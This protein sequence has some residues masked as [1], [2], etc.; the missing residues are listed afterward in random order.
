MQTT[1]YGGTAMAPSTSSPGVIGLIP[2]S[3]Q[4]EQQEPTFAVTAI[5]HSEDGDAAAPVDGSGSDTT[6]SAPQD[7]EDD[8]QQQ[9]HE[10]QAEPSSGRPVNTFQL[11]S[12]SEDSK[13]SQPDSGLLDG[14][15]T[16]AASSLVNGSTTSD[17]DWPE[18]VE[19]PAAEAASPSTPSAAV[20]MQQEQSSSA[21]EPT[22][23][24]GEGNG[25][26]SSAT[27]AAIAAAFSPATKS[28]TSP[29]SS[30]SASSSPAPSTPSTT[31]SSSV[32]A[33]PK[34][35]AQAQP[36]QQ[37][38]AG[39]APDPS[40]RLVF[41]A[42]HLFPLNNTFV[43]K[44]I[45]LSPPGSHNRV[46]IGRQTTPKTA[47]NPANGYFDS[48]VLSRAHA[49]IWSRDGKIYIKDVKSSNGTFINGERL[50]QEAQ[51]SDDYEL[52]SED[53]VEF[54][55][56]IVS[57]DGKVVLHHKVACRVYVVIT[58]EDAVSIA[59]D[60]ANGYVGLPPSSASRS[61]LSLGPG[62]GAVGQ[63]GM[64]AEGAGGAG[65]AAVGGYAT[66]SAPGYDPATG[67][68]RPAAGK[69]NTASMINLDQ[70]LGR[71][72]SELKRSREAGQELNTISNVFTD[73]HD[74]LA[75]GLPPLQQ[76]PYQHLV[77]EAEDKSQ[78]NPGPGGKDGAGAAAV[79]D[80]DAA[81]AAA[82]AEE[83][84]AAADAAAAAAL[85]AKEEA[86]AKLK[87][88][89]HQAAEQAKTVSRL[90]IELS[91]TQASLADHIAKMRGLEEILAE[92]QLL[93]SEVDGLRWMVNDLNLGSSSTSPSSSMKG[94]SME[95]NGPPALSRAP[96]PPLPP[97]PSDAPAPSSVMGS[98]M[99]LPAE[100]LHPSHH[101]HHHFHSGGDAARHYPDHLGLH[102]DEPELEVMNAL[103]ARA[104]RKTP[105]MLAEEEER[106][107]V[108][109][110][111]EREGDEERRRL[112]LEH[113]GDDFD[114]G[115][116]VAS[117]DT[118]VP[119]S[120]P[121]APRP[122]SA[123]H[124]LGDAPK[125][126]VGMDELEQ[127]ASGG[128]SVSMRRKREESSPGL[129]QLADAANGSSSSR[130]V[131][132]WNHGGPSSGSSLFGG[133]GPAASSAVDDDDDDDD[134]DDNNGGELRKM[135]H[136]GPLAPPDMPAGMS[137]QSEP[138][139]GSEKQQR[140]S[141]NGSSSPGSGGARMTRA[142]LM[143]ENG[144][145]QARL[146]SL[147]EM[148]SEAL[149]LGRALARETPGLEDAFKDVE[150]AQQQHEAKT[151]TESGLGLGEDEKDGRKEAGAVKVES[152]E[153][154]VPKSN[155]K[156]DD[157]SESTTGAAAPVDM[158]AHVRQLEARIA[159]LESEMDRRV[160]E[161]ESEILRETQA[162][163]ELWRAQAEQ[164]MQLERDSWERDHGRIFRKVVERHENETEADADV[165]EDEDRSARSASSGS[166]GEGDHTDSGSS[167]AASAASTNATS[168]PSSIA[169]SVGRFGRTL[170]GN[171]TGGK[172]TG[173]ASGASSVRSVAVAAGKEAAG[174]AKG[175]VGSTSS[176]TDE[177]RAGVGGV[178]S[179]GGT[180]RGGSSRPFLFS[181]NSA[182]LPALSAAGAVIVAMAV[183]AFAAKSAGPHK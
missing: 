167:S 129:L 113:G 175:V 12:D 56:D 104:K 5:S 134:D 144:K 19:A 157:S 6:I 64:G 125:P 2:S 84:K 17:Y 132:G 169:E 16:D 147:E 27:G 99:S 57:E 30:S 39:N 67:A 33:S 4:G 146:A 45:N 80:A 106:M 13:S 58:Q 15:V 170:L 88:T 161:V 155:A 35:Q 79:S 178:G 49:E 140:G 82:A 176:G 85:Q 121:S 29:P 143:E 23:I 54:G 77:P 32:A 65:T 177:K 20:S 73:I 152:V 76:P 102:A 98:T 112:R 25:T 28:G 141:N 159:S 118:V 47:P 41:P 59:H 183:M 127:E 44:C 18:G 9:Q 115:A 8:Q 55:I 124:H 130:S 160:A 173:A 7:A 40:Q 81:A 90:Q 172:D 149:A 62:P 78:P 171:G 110:Q 72:Q 24:G 96:P 48:K 34:P 122:S 91:E 63:G 114:D 1:S 163:W 137:Y 75:G 156:A 139:W 36:Q 182:T 46:K 38:Q 89:T 70:V 69:N 95:L 165:E 22:T 136:V 97:L 26:I 53:H 52:H 68:R 94:S 166:T 120:P 66:S 109:D 31:P 103:K 83:A 14:S 145:L 74:T 50:S 128:L 93:K 151:E 150:L 138:Y 21:A 154:N 119:G 168:P 43:P 116:S 60:I 126:P 101:A 71:L 51:E 61:G 10:G 37:P 111:R 92:H 86:E 179:G 148:L 142:Q 87:L 164:G 133:M 181:D 131:E 117:V 123:S 158:D 42:L 108:L 162:K 11:L 153:T 180:S 105:A 135:G 107:R 100:P 3:L 174:L